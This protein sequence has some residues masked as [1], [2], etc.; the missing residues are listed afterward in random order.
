MTRLKNDDVWR[1]KSMTRGKCQK[2]HRGDAWRVD[3]TAWSGDAS[4]KIWLVPS[5]SITDK[6]CEEDF[7][8]NTGF[9]TGSLIPRISF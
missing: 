6:S 7:A 2:I 9:G 3:K 1:E 8:S 4:T 5:S